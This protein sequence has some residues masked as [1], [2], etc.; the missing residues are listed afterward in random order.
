VDGLGFDLSKR[1]EQGMIPDQYVWLIWSS[2]FLIPWLAA[3]AAFPQQRN[4]MVRASLFTTPFGLTEPL[5]VPAYWNPPSL[6][7]LARM[8][9]FDIESLIFSFGIG[10]VGAVIY[11]L[12][13]S[14][15]LVPVAGAERRSPRHT[16]HKWALVVPFI[17]FPI[18]YLLPWNPIYPA[19]VAL[20]LGAVAAI[21]CRPDLA[22]K[23]W[24][25]AIL[26]VAYYAVFLLGVE[27]TAPG[28]IE[29]VWNLDALSGLGVGGMPIE[30]LLFAA[31]FGAC[32]SGVYDH[33]TWRTLERPNAGD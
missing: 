3:F 7:N 32:W 29:R 16:L 11:N 8:T 12:V 23:T 14:R 30:E 4:V 2:A 28:Y 10:G 5:F 24:V 33:F 31:A 18:L 26:F 9:G 22:R 17:S 19:I 1:Q 15:Q 20:V 25:G 27:W 6:F 21:W 13:I